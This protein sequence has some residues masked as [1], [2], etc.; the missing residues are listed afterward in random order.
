VRVAV[1]AVQDTL[2]ATVD[3]IS[4]RLDAQS[5]TCECI[6]RFRNEG[7]R[8][9]PG[10]FARAEIA[11]FIYPGRMMVP[12]A[13][14]LIRDDRPLVFKVVGDRAHWLYVT[15]GLENDNWIEITAVHSGGSLAPGEQVVV[16]DHL[17]LAH[18]AKIDIRK[19]EPPVDRW[20]FALAGEPQ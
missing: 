11:G 15:T 18:E 2:E 7:G 20:A 4:P 3:V 6:I 14:V 17:T 1:P 13:A 9:R 5:R 16:S 12:R 8:F 10:M 19:V